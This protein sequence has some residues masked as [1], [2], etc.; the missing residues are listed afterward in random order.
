MCV[1]WCNHLEEVSRREEFPTFCSTAP[2]LRSK[3][4]FILKFLNAFNFPVSDLKPCQLKH[5]QFKHLKSRTHFPFLFNMQEQFFCFGLSFICY[6]SCLDSCLQTYVLRKI[7]T[8]RFMLCLCKHN[9][10]WNN[11]VLSFASL[12]C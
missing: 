11:Q 6:L 8:A 3:A 2:R 9:M 7:K 10:K 5:C 12:V 4:W 1:I